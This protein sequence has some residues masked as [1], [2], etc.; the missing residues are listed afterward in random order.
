MAF[1][2]IVFMFSVLKWKMPASRC[3]L[4]CWMVLAC[5]L[6][7]VSTNIANMLVKASC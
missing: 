5:L 6:D 2:G 3:W 7:G 4:V 1:S